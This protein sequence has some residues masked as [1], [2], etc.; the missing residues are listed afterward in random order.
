MWLV[1][2]SSLSDR[3]KSSVRDRLQSRFVSSK[4]EEFLKD[5]LASCNFLFFSLFSL[6]FVVLSSS[7]FSYDKV[8]VT[9]SFEFSVSVIKRVTLC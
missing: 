4:H 5:F 9:L 3:A 8:S 6:S 1:V 2:K 7:R